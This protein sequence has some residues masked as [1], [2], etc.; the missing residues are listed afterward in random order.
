M[1]HVHFSPWHVNSVISSHII[2]S[3]TLV[4][5]INSF[6][7]QYLWLI[8]RGIPPI[9]ATVSGENKRRILLFNKNLLICIFAAGIQRVNYHSA[10]IICLLH[11]RKEAEEKEGTTISSVTAS[12]AGIAQLFG[13]VREELFFPSTLLRRIISDIRGLFVEDQVEKRR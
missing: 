9:I 8:K 4:F 11:I 13:N 12:E 10:F 7:N 3:G 6:L 1:K 2:P 5:R